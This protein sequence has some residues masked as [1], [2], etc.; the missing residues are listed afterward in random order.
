V[1][2]TLH[3][4]NKISYEVPAGTYETIS[5]LARVVPEY[6]DIKDPIEVSISRDKYPQCD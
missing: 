1:F 3:K 6:W 5:V 4:N 2:G